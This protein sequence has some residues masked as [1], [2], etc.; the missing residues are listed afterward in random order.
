VIR[1]AALAFALATLPA[2]AQDHIEAPGLLTDDDFYRAVACAAPPGGDCQKPFEHWDTSRPI[3]VAL[4]AIDPAYLG[5]RAKVA[6]SAFKLGLR[7]LN[8]AEAGFRL[9][10]VPAGENAEIE[11][12]FLGI[13]HGD[14]ISGTGIAHVDG[15]P[16]GDATTR[17]L[18]NHETGR[19]ERA[20]IVFSTTLDTT[21]FAPV[22][23]GALT[24]TMGLLTGIKSPA[25]DGISVLAQGIPAATTL[26]LQDIMALK[27]HY[28]RN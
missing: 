17:V 13:E 10:E 6:K 15:A 4:R 11:V 18:F 8:A 3:R 7:A 12:W 16:M 19:I 14:A 24:Q 21:D 22:M 23:L 2:A 25:Y 28:A 9:S 20:A 5:R 27:R 26:G 1:P